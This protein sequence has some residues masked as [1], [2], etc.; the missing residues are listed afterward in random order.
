MKPRLLPLFISLVMC[1]L[2]CQA[3][4]AQTASTRR[5]LQRSHLQRQ[6]VSLLQDSGKGYYAQAQAVDEI[7]LPDG[8]PGAPLIPEADP[9]VQAAP[10]NGFPVTTLPD[11]FG[12]AIGLV[13]DPV[14]ADE[15]AIADSIN[16]PSEPVMDNE[17]R[18]DSSMEIGDGDVFAA[19]DSFVEEA[20]A[21]PDFDMLPEPQAVLEPVA[22]ENGEQCN[23]DICQLKREGYE[24]ISTNTVFENPG[25]KQFVKCVCPGN[26]DICE[27]NN[28][29]PVCGE[30]PGGCQIGGW[31]AWGTYFN[32]HGLRNS[33]GNAP[34][35][36]NNI[37]NQLQ[38][39]QAWIYAERPLANDQ[40]S[41]GYRTDFLF[42][43]DAPDTQA[44]GDGGWDASWDTSGQ[45]GFALPQLYL[46][47]SWQGW[48]AKLGRFFTI[49]GYETVQAPNNFFYSHAYTQYYNEPFTHTGV[50]F[51]RNLGDDWTIYAGWTA[52]WDSGFGNNFGGSTFLGGFSYSPTDNFA[53]TYATSI[54]DS[55]V[56]LP[57]ANSVYSHS[58]ILDFAFGRGWN[59]I[60]Q[61]DLQYRDSDSALAPGVFNSKQYGINQYLIKKINCR[62][63]AGTR[64]EWLYAGEGNGPPLNRPIATPGSHYHAITFGLNYQRSRSLVIKPE[65]RY[66]WVDFDGPPGGTFANGTKRSQFAAGFQSIWSW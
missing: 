17:V 46:Q 35:G 6:D 19:P 34:L 11:D 47:A 44:F 20:F 27:A 60:F 3:V 43:S 7:P 13:E 4:M 36:F 39:H 50:L 55:G 16:G 15:A 57:G 40:A 63:S 30:S 1:S 32:S 8:V 28:S 61:T 22:L 2:T 24:V 64:V 42:G 51:D 49:L 9:P 10:S 31:L 21:G 41:W 65:V 5:L 54:G 29:A 62:W 56:D 45:Y 37:S 38:L 18:I 59:Y 26:C 52:G 58:I 12:S 25:R 33:T 53:A 66:D 14:N 23:C 48:R